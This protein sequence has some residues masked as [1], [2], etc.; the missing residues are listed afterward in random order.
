[1]TNI[2]DSEVMDGIRLRAASV[3]EQCKDSVGG[4]LDVYV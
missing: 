1:M 2:L 4:Y 3:V